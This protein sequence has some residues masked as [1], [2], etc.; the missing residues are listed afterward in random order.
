MRVIAY[1]LP[2]FHEIPENNEW[3]GN[4]FTEW[5]NVRKAIPL[6]KDHYQP[7]VPGELGYYDL[8]NST[9]REAQAKLAKDSGIEAFCYWHYWFG[10]GIQL[11]EMPF[12]EVINTKSPDIKFC[13]GWANESW[14]AK[15]WSNA[16]D[17][18][19]KTLMEQKYPGEQDIIDHF[20]HLLSAFKDNRFVQVDGKPL[21]VIYR[22]LLLPNVNRFIEIWNTLAIQNG[23]NGIYFVGHTL[24][25]F[26]INKII[27]LGFDAVNV[28]RLG[29]CRR[30]KQLILKNLKNLFLYAI[31]RK[32]FV[33]TYKSAI[34]KLCGKENRR[35]DVFPSIIPNWD[36]T[37]R[38]AIN[39]FVL[40]DSTPEYFKKHVKQI[41]NSISHKPKKKQI[42]FLKSWNEW[43]EGNYIEPDNKFGDKYLK[44]LKSQIFKFKQL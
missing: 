26:D 11:L 10:N 38:S 1:Y 35:I 12:K 41:F 29:D 16:N 17:G 2:Q 7:K 9:I 19:D 14:K 37:P 39:G 3:W 44:I 6:F 15:V 40:H 43:G 30:S 18:E 28:V 36:H 34:S 23:L 42:V 21:F 24:Y 32:P 13:L 8:N 20:Y 27:K 22:P 33:Y 31:K 5:T 25:S 4:G